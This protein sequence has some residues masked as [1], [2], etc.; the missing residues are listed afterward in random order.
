MTEKAGKAAVSA[1]EGKAAAETAASGLKT[2]S[3][4]GTGLVSILGKIPTPAKL[5]ITTVAAL[6]LGVAIAMKKAHDAAV[7]ADLAK[8]FGSV[9]LSAEECQKVVEHLTKT[10]WTVK[11]KMAM[12]A[13]NNVESLE[14]NL[15]STIAT[16]EKMNWKVSVGME[17]TET[18]KSSYKQACSDYVKQATDYVESQHYAVSLALQVGFNVNSATYARLSQFSNNLYSSTET[19]LA[20]LGQQLADAVNKAFE[21]GTFSKHYKNPK[22][23]QR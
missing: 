10:D 9:K 8:H 14:K 22:T 16:I 12:D 7:S 11:L 6:G 18:E 1:T 2:A 13:K 17:L 5:V 19:E 20:T 21:N 3:S 4:A 15:E 23:N